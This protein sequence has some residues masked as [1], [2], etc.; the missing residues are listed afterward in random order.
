MITVPAMYQAVVANIS[1][2]QG[3][4]DASVQVHN[5]VQPACYICPSQRSADFERRHESFHCN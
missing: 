3:Q 1:Q 4:S 5:R 2:M